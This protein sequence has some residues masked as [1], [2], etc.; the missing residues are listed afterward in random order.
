MPKMP[1]ANPMRDDM[2]LTSTQSFALPVLL[3]LMDTNHHLGEGRSEVM[4]H[5][6]IQLAMKGN[7][8]KLHDYSRYWSD[9][10]FTPTKLMMERVSRLIDTC[11]WY[12]GERFV[13]KQNDSTLEYV[14]KKF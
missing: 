10:S 7:K 8:V 5:V 14:G 2:V 11:H 6:L 13:I 12:K 4:A 1:P 3:W 9:Q